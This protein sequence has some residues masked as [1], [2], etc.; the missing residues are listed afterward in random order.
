MSSREKKVLLLFWLVATAFNITKAV[1]I[2]DTVHLLIAKHITVHP[3]TPYSGWLNWSSEARPM[4]RVSQPPLLFYIYAG[5][6]KVFGDSILLLHL[7]QSFF[8]FGCIYFFYRIA[9]LLS[10][11]SPLSLTAVFCL[12]PAFIPSQNLMT[13]V[14]LLCFM[15]GATFFLF[16]ALANENK[17]I[18]YFYS[19]IHISLALLTKYTALTLL[20][21]MLVCCFFTNRKALMALLGIPIIALLGWMLLSFLGSQSI[22]PLSKIGFWSREHDI[23]T[24]LY[25]VICLGGVAPF[26]LLAFSMVRTH[27]AMFLCVSALTLATLFLPDPEIK[28]NPFTIAGHTPS[29]TL[30]WLNGFFIFLATIAL[31]TNDILQSD[32][33]HKAQ[34][35]LLLFWLAA[36]V[37]F[38]TFFAP[39]AAVRHALIALPAILLALGRGISLRNDHLSKI[40]M[41]CSLLFT[42]SLGLLLGI[43]DWVLANGYKKAA[44]DLAETYL[45]NDKSTWLL[46]H[47]GLQWY[48]EHA[49]L[50][51]YDANTSLLQE[52]DIVINPRLVSKQTVSEKY[53][54][55]LE[56][57]DEVK[58]NFTP[59]SYFRTM[60][61]SNRSGFY[62]S[63][64]GAGPW[65]LS[66]EPLEVFDIFKVSKK[67]RWYNS[68][69]LLPTTINL[70]SH[71][72]S[73]R[74]LTLQLEHFLPENFE[75]T[76][77]GSNTSPKCSATILDSNYL[78]TPGSR[79]VSITIEASAK[80][81]TNEII[82]SCNTA[83]RESVK[84]LLI[85]SKPLS[86][87][88]EFDLGT[89]PT[90]GFHA[91]D[92]TIRLWSSIKEADMFLPKLLHGK[93][94]LSFNAKSLS[95]DKICKLAVKV[96]RQ[97]S[98]VSLTSKQSSYELEFSLNHPTNKISFTGP[99]PLS[100]MVLGLDDPRLLGFS[101]SD[102]SIAPIEYD[103]E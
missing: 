41:H 100:G 88:T 97:E 52:G 96:G 32:T 77:V 31:L 13:D 6:M 20:P 21:G 102:V 7:I 19:G 73:S 42:C 2:D 62:S 71:D 35:S 74:T 68:P 44:S 55:L 70:E 89:L 72:D 91:I 25:F 59:L 45:S 78:P 80:E 46:G 60:S 51:I 17:V 23:E 81:K 48:G 29:L 101:V 3:L 16:R 64:I 63:R 98:V 34:A 99:E 15:L 47:W 26:S 92:E 4:S 94:K 37:P 61:P 39:A 95:K 53:R 76:L 1:H 79:S 9:V 54:P 103:I 67:A 93:F 43:S 58:V 75:L 69:L 83:V 66:R 22:H 28:I 90:R 18:D 5:V 33:R 65:R 85:H 11:A 8:T 87:K 12:G 24:F 84:S 30:F 57:I 56:K 82:L 38:V 36:L 10:I 40:L 14:P 49:G 50:Q 86:E 27:R